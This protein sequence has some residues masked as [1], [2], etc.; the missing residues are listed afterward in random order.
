[1]RIMSAGMHLALVKALVGTLVLFR[2][3]K[4]VDISS[5]DYGLARA[6]CGSLDFGINAGFTHAHRIQ[7]EAFKLGFDAL[8]SA[9]LLA[10]GL[11]VLME[12][13]TERDQVIPVSPDFF[14][15]DC[16]NRF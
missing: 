9:E 12:I 5:E 1:M 6:F 13:T 10:G 4:G 14:S 7:T 8:G 11:G 16:F 3:R 2:Y 15:D